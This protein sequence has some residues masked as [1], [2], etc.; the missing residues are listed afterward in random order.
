MTGTFMHSG[1]GKQSPDSTVPSE[2]RTQNKEQMEYQQGN[3]RLEEHTIN[4]LNLVHIYITFQPTT[5]NDMFFQ[6][7]SNYLSR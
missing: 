3:R 7:F 4:S 1:P 5:S 2:Q 6:L